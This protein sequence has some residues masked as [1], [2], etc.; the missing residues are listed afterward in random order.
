MKKY[1]ISTLFLLSGIICYPQS[2][3]TEPANKIQI[4]YKDILELR[5]QVLALQITSGTY[6][7]PEKGKVDY[8]VSIGISY[9]KKI[10]FGIE[11]E[12]KNTLSKEA[13]QNIIEEG[14]VFVKR[15][16]T[17]LIRNNYPELNIDYTK[18]ISGFWYL[19][20]GD[21]PYAKWENDKFL[22][23]NQ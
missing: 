14:F 6:K 1:L 5:L 17:E 8:S 11:K 15:S 16:I 10:V 4:T 22:W 2:V 18:D 9:P 21:S 3:K 20:N 19:K 13:Q 23:I 7:S 12:V